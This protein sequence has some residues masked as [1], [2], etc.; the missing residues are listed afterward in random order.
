MDY[1]TRRGHTAN[2]ESNNLFFHMQ[3]PS[4][5]RPVCQ[6][7]CEREEY[8]PQRRGRGMPRYDEWGRAGRKNSWQAL[9]SLSQRAE[10][11]L[12]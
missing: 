4:V 5:L 12:K 9:Q 3:K 2:Q 10:E 8:L 6:V 1:I 7:A 11:P